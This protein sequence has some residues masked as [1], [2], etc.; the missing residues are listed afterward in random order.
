[1]AKKEKNLKA[2]SVSLIGMLFQT[3]AVSFSSTFSHSAGHLISWSPYAITSMLS[4]FLDAGAIS[5]LVTTIP[6]LF[7]KFS[8][9]WPSLIFM[10]TSKD[11][12]K[13]KR[14]LK[15]DFST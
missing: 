1:V 8:L 7:A 3:T 9:L 4:M 6:T 2:V 10:N 14:G 13:L 5:P 11:L 12:Q 15:Q